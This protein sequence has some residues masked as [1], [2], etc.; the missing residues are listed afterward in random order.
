[1][2]KAIRAALLCDKSDEDPDVG[3]VLTGVAGDIVRA[4]TRP[5]LLK[6]WLFVML[7]L[8]EH[9]TKVLIKVEAADYA[10][11]YPVDFPGGWT[12]T[13]V[14]IPMVVPV[15]REGPLS[16]AVRDDRLT[17]K[18]F[19]YKWRLA[20]TDGAKVLSEEEAERLV[21]AAQLTGAVQVA[22]LSDKV[23]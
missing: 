19:R 10:Q 15:T 13:S 23:N 6:T 8:D 18:P 1:M 16:I 3:L 14:S 12:A 22:S 11:E 21:L 7:D 20:F 17:S 4:D 9:P 5:G 2:I